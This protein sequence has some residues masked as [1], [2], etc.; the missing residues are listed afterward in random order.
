[1]KF[2][3]SEYFKSIKHS[4]IEKPFGTFY[5]CE[6][7]FIAELNE[8]VHFDWEMVKDVMSDVI[9][10]YGAD[11]KL[12]YLSNRV[13]SYSMNPHSWEKVYKK[14]GI[15][16]ASAIVAYNNFT[17]MNAAIEKQFSSKSIKRCYSLTE[18][19]NWISNLKELN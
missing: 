5:F 17:S 1:M 13:N 9:K 19:V 4:K 18:A 11:A 14:Y 10:F 7:F 8:S 3:N 12:G 2:E 15:L 6:R 16:V